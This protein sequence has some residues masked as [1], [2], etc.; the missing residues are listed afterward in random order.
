ML[1]FASSSRKLQSFK[2]SWKS[3]TPAGRYAADAGT[4]VDHFKRHVEL[5][6]G[7][8]AAK[9]YDKHFARWI[10]RLCQHDQNADYF[11]F[12]L[13]TTL[14]IAKSPE[15]PMFIRAIRQ[16]CEQ[17][18]L[19][20]FP[21]LSRNHPERH[22]TCQ[23]IAVVVLPAVSASGRL[24]YHGWIRVPKAASQKRASILI[25]QDGNPSSIIGS[26]GLA[27]FV[28]AL[29]YDADAPFR[30]S[31]RHFTSFWIQHKDGH[32]QPT[33]ANDSTG[34]FPYLRKTADGEMRQWT[35]TEFIPTLVL[36]RVLKS[37]RQQRQMRAQQI[38][39]TRKQPYSAA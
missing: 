17:T 15:S 36:A 30:T 27:E 14:P 32:A 28:K 2:R 33:S 5:F 24:H 37:I 23:S 7:R 21:T 19:K 6:A 35:W 1:S 20:L 29:V 18:T 22:P 11:P 8:N 38:K 25:R 12:A 34:E 16:V 31:G 10:R 9:I 4:N 13:N 3:D 39:Q 26:E